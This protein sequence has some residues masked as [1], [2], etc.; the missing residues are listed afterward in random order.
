MLS[1][2]LLGWGRVCD[3]FHTVLFIQGG[4]IIPLRLMS[5]VTP[6][7]ISDFLDSFSGVFKLFPTRRKFFITENRPSVC[8]ADSVLERLM[9]SLRGGR[10]SLIL[11]FSLTTDLQIIAQVQKVTGSPN[12]Q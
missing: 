4:H 11:L 12:S 10:R 3:F 9:V 8:F 5:L 6:N 2:A 1:C 7:F